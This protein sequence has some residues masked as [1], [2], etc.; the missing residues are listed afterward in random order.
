MYTAEPWSQVLDIG[1]KLPKEIQVTSLDEMIQMIADA[2]R[3]I[4]VQVRLADGVSRHQRVCIYVLAVL[5]ALH[6]SL[7]SSN[8]TLPPLAGRSKPERVLQRLS[9]RCP[10]YADNLHPEPFPGSCK[11]GERHQDH[12]RN[13]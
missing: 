8:G 5:T 10:I 3:H 4:H 13:W 12:K 9:Q 6:A 2:K 1:D 7:L 11:V